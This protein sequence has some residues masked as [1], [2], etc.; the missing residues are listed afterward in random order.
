MLQLELLELLLQELLVLQQE[1]LLVLLEL[2]LLEQLQVLQLLLV[3]Q[4]LLLFCCKRSKHSQQGCD[5]QGFCH[6]YLS[7]TRLMLIC[8]E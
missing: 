7:I 4:E 6:D 8:D 1:L 5:Q 3:L 2:L